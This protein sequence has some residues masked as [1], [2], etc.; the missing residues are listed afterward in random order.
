M[1]EEIKLIVIENQNK[2]CHC[3]ICPYCGA[4]ELE[5]C[6]ETDVSKWRFQIKA[7]RVDNA[8]HCLKCGRWFT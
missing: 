2:N 8:S 3:L 6:Q 1:T 5:N 7:F 4:H